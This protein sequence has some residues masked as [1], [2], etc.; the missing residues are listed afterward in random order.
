MNLIALCGL[1]FAFWG[2]APEIQVVPVSNAP[3]SSSQELEIVLP[4][5]EEVLQEG[6]IYLQFRVD[7]FSLGTIPDLERAK[8]LVNA[9]KGQSIRIIIDEKH[10]LSYA[11]P[12]IAPFDEDGN[13]YQA[14]SRIKLPFSLEKGEHIIRAFLVRSFGESIKGD[15]TFSMRQFF[16]KEKRINKELPDLKEPILTYNQ[17]APS[18]P[19]SEKKPVLLDFYLSNCEISKDGY[20]VKVI[21][22]DKEVR[23]LTD[24]NP[25]YIYGLTKG[26]HTVQIE[27]LDENKRLVGGAFN[28]IKKQIWVN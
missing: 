7:G 28:R 25:Y 18:F 14:N 24:W 27:L 9:K 11:G 19:F 5:K 2:K 20:Q 8:E 12:S 15:D 16:V 1:F 17:P 21:I 22:D 10:T 26:S 3:S 4:E 13:Y 23:F 6:P